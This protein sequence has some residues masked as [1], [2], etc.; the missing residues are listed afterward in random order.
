MHLL[1]FRL[2]PHEFAVLTGIAVLLIFSNFLV[3]EFFQSLL[4]LTCW[5]VVIC[6]NKIH[7]L[8]L[9]NCS[10]FGVNKESI[11]TFSFRAVNDGHLY[12]FLQE[13]KSYLSLRTSKRKKKIKT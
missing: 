11:S 1:N 7:Q 10:P 3:T 5:V 13:Y 9:S 8:H 4:L 12:G 2:I 6:S